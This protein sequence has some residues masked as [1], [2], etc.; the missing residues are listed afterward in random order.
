MCGSPSG[1]RPQSGGQAAQPYYTVRITLPP[2]DVARL[3]DIRLVPGMPADAFIRT[4]D[5]SPLQ[6]SAQ[7]VRGTD[8]ADLPQAVIKN[9]RSRKQI[10]WIFRE[11]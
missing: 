9:Y 8:R 6:L 10:A 2:E 5:R 7:S 3:K 4:H 11:R 1:E